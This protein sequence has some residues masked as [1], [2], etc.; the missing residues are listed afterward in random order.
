MTHP[1]PFNPRTRLAYDLPSA[2]AVRRRVYDV[3]G[4]LV[5]T[6]VESRQEAGEQAV[7]WD[8]RD[9]A[10]RLLPSGI[11]LARLDGDKIAA[12]RKLVLVR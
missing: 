7:T 10:G 6:L 8:G 3:A 4:H 2:G 1:N 9:G 5:R 11:Y 12:S